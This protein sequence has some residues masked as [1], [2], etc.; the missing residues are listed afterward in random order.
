MTKGQLGWVGTTESE[1]AKLLDKK[2]QWYEKKKNKMNSFSP[3]AT[4]L[5][6]NHFHLPR[7]VIEKMEIGKSRAEN[8]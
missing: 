6:E 5:V 1:N 7:N 2:N 4:T 3:L 8:W